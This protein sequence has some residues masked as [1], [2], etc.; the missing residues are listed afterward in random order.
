MMSSSSVLL[1]DNSNSRTKARLLENGVITAESRWMPTAD[2]TP[3]SIRQLV[4]GWA[5][6]SVCVASV[7]PAA[8]EV[9]SAAFECPVRF[10]SVT[11]SLPVNFSAYPGVA[12]LGADRVANVLA[13][14]EKGKYPALAIDL[15]TAITFD[16]LTGSVESPV[17]GGGVIAPGLSALRNYLGRHTALLPQVELTTDC[18]VIGTNTRE[19]ILSG[20]S[21]GFAGL[22]KEHICRIR[23]QLEAPLYVVATGG[24]AALAASLVP[25]IT[26]IDPLLT[27]KGIVSWLQFE[28]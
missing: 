14:A 25:E 20:I 11:H 6:E 22:V 18:P 16:V 4:A 15:G 21:G 28:S 3:E 8:A 7:V 27:F 13:L 2:I 9:L 5:F 12:T 1:I 26:E 23:A 24:D 10:V 17:F 19:A